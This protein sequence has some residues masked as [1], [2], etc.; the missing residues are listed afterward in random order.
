LRV[1]TLL[2]MPDCCAL[3]SALDQQARLASFYDRLIKA[4]HTRGL[5]VVAR[6]QQLAVAGEP[7]Q[8]VRP[9]GG[10]VGGARL[11]LPLC[12]EN[13]ANTGSHARKQIISILCIFEYERVNSGIE[14][15]QARDVNRHM[16]PV[17]PDWGQFSIYQF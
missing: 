5:D 17:G 9:A 2:K 7:R 11:E 13:G 12:N 4:A 15:P 6:L 14:L 8:D 1:E 3:L 10:R 16:K